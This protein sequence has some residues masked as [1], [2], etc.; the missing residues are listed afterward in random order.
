MIEQGSSNLRELIRILIRNL[1]LLE[2][3]DASCCGI[4]TA[5]CHAIVEIGIKKKVSLVELS[6]K[7]LLDKSTMSRTINKLVESNIVKRDLDEDNRR[8][9]AI[10]LT[11]YGERIFKKVEDSMGNYYDNIFIN[12]PKEKRDCVLES[13]DVLTSAVKS[14]N[15]SETNMGR[16]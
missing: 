4:T 14:T 1:D 6:E 11:L 13:L 9:V 16:D 10:E 5:Q 7:L 2:K 8:Y 12:I 3:R 15:L